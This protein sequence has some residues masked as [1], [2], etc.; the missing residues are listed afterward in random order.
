MLGEPVIGS[1]PEFGG[2]LS[3]LVFMDLAVG[4]AEMVVDGCVD[5]CVT[6]EGAVLATQAR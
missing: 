4:Q 6:A 3:R 2:G 5:I 1:Q